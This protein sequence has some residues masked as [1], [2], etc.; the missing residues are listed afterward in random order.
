MYNK[1]YLLLILLLIFYNCASFTNKP[2]ESKSDSIVIGINIY[3]LVIDT[4]YFINLDEQDSYLSNKKLIRSNLNIGNK[5]YLLNAKPGR[6]II[7]VAR[8]HISTGSKNSKT[9]YYLPLKFIKFT[10]ITV[11]EGHICYLGDYYLWY[12]PSLARGIFNP[13]E[14]QSFYCNRFQPSKIN[15]FLP[16]T[17][18]LVSGVVSEV[19]FGASESEYARTAYIVEEEKYVPLTEVQ[20]WEKTVEWLKGNFFQKMFY[21]EEL[22]TNEEWINIINKK[23]LL[24]KNKE[25]K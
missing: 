7:V 11:K 6:Y 15:Q 23:L 19:I 4:L 1:K 5:F 10:D 21:E 18:E 2:P 9:T 13:D 20:F 17:S 12:E 25:S 24:L 22:A 3:G 14:A 16:S 8:S